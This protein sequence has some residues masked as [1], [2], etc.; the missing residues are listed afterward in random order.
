[1]IQRKAHKE[2][3]INNVNAF[4]SVWLEKIYA[5]VYWFSSYLFLMNGA[6]HIIFQAL[7]YITDTHDISVAH[8][9]Q[10]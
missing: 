7:H 2:N 5:N 8:Y 6:L 10:D 3:C 4:L 1:M 9:E